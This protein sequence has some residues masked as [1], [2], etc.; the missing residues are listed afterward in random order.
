[1]SKIVDGNV[2]N[3]P[4]LIYT[5]S[6]KYYDLH[7]CGASMISKKDALTA[8][9]CVYDYDTEEANY[10]GIMVKIG[11]AHR[12]IGGEL[13]SV[14]HIAIH[15]DFKP[16]LNPYFYADIAVVTVSN[17]TSNWILQTF[18]FSSLNN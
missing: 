18:R 12:F 7:K 8:A 17:Y 1:M 13:F 11:G 15:P 14:K 6:I 2:I 16:N 4:N 9:H 5:V 10:Y 3:F